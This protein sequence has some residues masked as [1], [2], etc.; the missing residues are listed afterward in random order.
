M[1]WKLQATPRKK[2]GLAAVFATVSLEFSFSIIVACLPT[3]TPLFKKLPILT[4][5][6]PTLRSKITRSNHS[7]SKGMKISGPIEDHDIERNALRSEEHPP[8]DW[9]TPRAWNEVGRKREWDNY[10]GTGEADADDGG[11]TV[12]SESDVTLQDLQPVEGDAVGKSKEQGL[13]EFV[14]G[15]LGRGKSG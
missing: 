3:L 6:I 14:E 5:W 11:T 10:S 13:R 2:L 8:A 15:E 9:Q 12:R 1:V 7:N 4:T